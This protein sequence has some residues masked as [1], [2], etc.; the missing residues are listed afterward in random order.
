MHLEKFAKLFTTCLRDVTDSVLLYRSSLER[1]PS[2]IF[3]WLFIQIGEKYILVKVW[4]VS[5]N[6]P[7]WFTISV[8]HL[9]RV[10]RIYNIHATCNLASVH[11]FL[12]GILWKRL[13]WE[14]ALNFSPALSH[15]FRSLWDHEFRNHF[16]KIK[17]ERIQV[18]SQ[19]YLASLSSEFYN[20]SLISSSVLAEDK[21]KSP[22]YSFVL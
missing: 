15:I 5:I 3:G 7:A 14:I 9:I 18:I 6:K 12:N 20:W 22:F 8:P 19:F 2:M 16:A 21:S 11:E 13:V 10:D 1:K 4:R 17:F